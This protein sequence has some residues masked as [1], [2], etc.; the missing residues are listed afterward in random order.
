MP[1]S[2]D[3]VLFEAGSASLANPIP[4]PEETMRD[5]NI[6]MPFLQK[7]EDLGSPEMAANREE[8][9]PSARPANVT[10]FRRQSDALPQVPAERRPAAPQIRARDIFPNSAPAAL[11]N[12]ARVWASL[13]RIE[14]DLETLAGNGLFPMAEEAGPA[15]RFDLLRTQM[16]H[17]LAERGWSRI[18]L[19]A[20]RRGCGTTLIAANLALSFARRPD[21]RTVL[22]DLD[23]R[24]PALARLFGLTDVPPL[25]PYLSEDQPLESHF[26][27]IGTGLALGANGRGESDPSSILHGRA[28]DIALDAIAAQLEPG[29]IL[30]DLPPLL[31]GDEVLA[32]KPQLDAVILVA[33]GTST[34]P[35]DLN[36]C[37]RLLDGQLPILA[38][39][40]NRGEDAARTR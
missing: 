3:G 33:D 10:L 15:Q 22:V 31:D 14:P 21:S 37:T 26:L 30:Y 17:A 9:R 24:R 8:N 7:H 2:C 34:S 32:L 6:L 28:C 12:S 1:P 5:H 29:V 16:L 19:T 38:A 23:L 20:P 40:L 39:I 11:V 36:A 18:G 35:G 27:R 13:N 25:R 4:G